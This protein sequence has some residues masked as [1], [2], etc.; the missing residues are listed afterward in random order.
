MMTHTAPWCTS[1]S[2]RVHG[3]DFRADDEPLHAM[4]L[5]HSAGMHVF[6]CRT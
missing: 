1:T 2:R 3:L 6:R 4:P 5:Y